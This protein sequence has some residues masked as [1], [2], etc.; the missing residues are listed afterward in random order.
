MWRM[1][2]WGCDGWRKMG[3]DEMMDK[4]IWGCLWEVFEEVVLGCWKDLILERRCWFFL[5]GYWV[6]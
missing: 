4:E 6:F 1:L 2:W 3:G 5:G